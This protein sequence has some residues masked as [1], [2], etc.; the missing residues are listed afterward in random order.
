MATNCI[1]GNVSKCILLMLKFL[2][3]TFLMCKFFKKIVLF[4]YY[5]LAAFHIIPYYFLKIVIS[6]K[7][8]KKKKKEDNSNKYMKRSSRSLAIRKK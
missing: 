4:K 3:Y 1:L 6:R 5:I 8:K 2:T 7:T